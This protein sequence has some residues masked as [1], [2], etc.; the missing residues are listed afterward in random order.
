MLSQRADL[1][2]Q[3]HDDKRKKSI[4]LAVIGSYTVIHDGCPIFCRYNLENGYERSLSARAPV[5][6]GG[7]EKIK[8]ASWIFRLDKFEFTG[9]SVHHQE[10]EDVCNQ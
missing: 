6:I 3:E 9:K 2:A 5:E 8:I 7:K 10:S 1:I 4:Q